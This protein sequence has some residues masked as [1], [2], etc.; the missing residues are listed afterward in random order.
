[1]KPMTWVKV[2]AIIAQARVVLTAAVG[3][4]NPGTSPDRLEM[5]MKRKNQS[6]DF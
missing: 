1:M 3:G 2:T 5:K 4:K 6:K